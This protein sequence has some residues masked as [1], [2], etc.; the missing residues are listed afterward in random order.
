MMIDYNNWEYMTQHDSAKYGHMWVDVRNSQLQY[1]CNEVIL[2][3]RKLDV[4]F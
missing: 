4:Q 2:L 3:A 1:I